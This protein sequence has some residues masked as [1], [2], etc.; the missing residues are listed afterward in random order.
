M[1]PSTR[2]PS[3]A[4][5]QETTD[6]TQL[7]GA[8]ASSNQKRKRP[9]SVDE[10]AENTP[11]AKKRQR[12][13]EPKPRQRLNLDLTTLA[14]EE[15]REQLEVLMKVLRK[16]RKI[17]VVAGAGISVSAGSTFLRS[18]DINFFYLQGQLQLISFQLHQ[19]PPS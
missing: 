9:N 17:V 15:Q 5:S 8:T 2:Y 3:P 4:S 11:L 18:T 16:R 7:D 19:T 12:K 1:S 10:A 13:S 6:T 14:D